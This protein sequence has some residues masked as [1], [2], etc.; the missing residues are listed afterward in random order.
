M[1]ERARVLGTILPEYRRCR[2]NVQRQR[3]PRCDDG[4]RRHQHLRGDPFSQSAPQLAGSG[5]LRQEPAL[6]ARVIRLLHDRAVE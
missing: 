3:L 6:V 4:Q 1:D 2:A 5:L